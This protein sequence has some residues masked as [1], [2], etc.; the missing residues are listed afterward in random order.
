MGNYDSPGNDL[1]NA[2]IVILTNEKL[3][4][5]IRNDS[6]LLSNVGLFVIDEIHLMGDK[7]R[8]PTLEM[9]ITKIKRFYQEAQILALSATVSISKDIAEWLNCKLI[10]N[11]WRPTELFEG[12]YDDGIVRMNNNTKIKIN[13]QKI[14]MLSTVRI[15]MLFR[16]YYSYELYH[17]HIHLQIV[18]LVS[19][20]FQLIYNLTIQLYLWN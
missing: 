11:N 7:N 19:N 14:R 4:A 18:Q 10:E 12:V 17:H 6:E 16:Y 20:Y 9:M 5:L 3:D 13:K 2:D 8:G 1:L 15:T